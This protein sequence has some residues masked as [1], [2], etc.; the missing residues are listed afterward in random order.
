[1]LK[2]HFLQSDEFKAM[3]ASLPEHIRWS[4]ERI[5]NSLRDTLSERPVD[6]DVWLFCYGSLIWNP[7]VQFIERQPATLAGWNRSFSLGLRSGPASEAQP[8]RMPGLEPGGETR[9]RTRL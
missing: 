1:M 5:A 7:V 2:R 6:G 4:P 8:G 3:L 9:G